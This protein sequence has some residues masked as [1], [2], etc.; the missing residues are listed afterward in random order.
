MLEGFEHSRSLLVA[1]P[2]GPSATAY[3]TAS[4]P[5]EVKTTF[6][7]QRVGP[8]SFTWTFPAHSATQLQLSVASPP[9]PSH[10]P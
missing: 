5:R 3:N 7:R 2:D 1:L 4:R 9:G 10:L 8:G 6:R